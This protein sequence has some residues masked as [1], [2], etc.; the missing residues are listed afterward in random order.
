MQKKYAD[1]PVQ[2]ILIPSNQFGSQEPGTNAEVKEFAEKYVKLGAGSNVI[3]LA[4]SNLNDM[5][6]KYKGPDA[7]KP[8]STYCCA[9]ND[10]VYKYLLAKAKPGEIKWNFDK[11]ITDASGV[12]YRDSSILRGKAL[13]DQLGEAIDDALKKSILTVITSYGD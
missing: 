2:F 13:D 4:K 9:Q 3:M 12:P 7:C 10:G 6:C 8:E 5:K 1:K 11:I